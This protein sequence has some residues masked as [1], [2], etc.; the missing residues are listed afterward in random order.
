MKFLN[1]GGVTLILLGK[2]GCAEELAALYTMADY[3]VNPTHEDNYPTTNLE[4]Q[5]CGTYV[6]TY[7]VGGCEET[8]K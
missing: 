5:A 6:I 3:Y 1:G 2:T 4:A 8:I 7:N